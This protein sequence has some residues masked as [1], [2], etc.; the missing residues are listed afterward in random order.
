MRRQFLLA[1]IA[2]VLAWPAAAQTP[3]QAPGSAPPTT[4]V[5]LLNGYNLLMQLGFSLVV[6]RPL[7]RDL[8]IDSS[9]QQL[10]PSRINRDIAGTRL[11]E[12][13][14]R[15]T[16]DV[17]AAYWNLVSANATVEARRSAPALAE[18]LA[19]VNKAKGDVGQSPPPDFVS[20]QAE[21]ASDQEQLIIAETSVKQTEDRLRLLIF[22][23]T[24]RDV[25]KMK[26]DPVDSPPIGTTALDVDAAVTRAL[27]E[28]ADLAR[29]RKDI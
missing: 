12:T 21:V 1:L 3:A 19:R 20:A 14:V 17:K 22:D 29:A 27:S 23:P 13:L 7:I 10:A 24:D 18:E 16:A 26:L 6:P 4:S 15:T 25:W 2:A 8:S 28:R 9:R 11:R 5:S